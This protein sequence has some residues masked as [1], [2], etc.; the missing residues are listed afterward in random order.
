MALSQEGRKEEAEGRRNGFCLFLPLSYKPYLPHYMYISL[1]P[2]LYCYYYYAT[3][4][5]LYLILLCLVPY[6]MYI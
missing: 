6:I 3:N 4:F 1:L 2:A 5:P